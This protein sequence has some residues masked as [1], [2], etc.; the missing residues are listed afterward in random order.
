MFGFMIFF[1]AWEIRNRIKEKEISFFW[2]LFF[3]MA[4][5]YVVV[6]YMV[7][8]VLVNVDPWWKPQHFITLEEW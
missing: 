2:P 5:S 4:I 6:S 8:A 1:V 3:S 7:T